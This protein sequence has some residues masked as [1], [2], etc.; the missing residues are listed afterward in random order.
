MTKIDYK[1]FVRKL[2][3]RAAELRAISAKQREKDLAGLDDETKSLIN[4]KLTEL[5]GELQTYATA[6]AQDAI[7]AAIDELEIV[8][9]YDAGQLVNDLVVPYNTSEQDVLSQLPA[10]V[11]IPGGNGDTAVVDVTW[12][13]EGYNPEVADVYSIIGTFTLPHLWTGLPEIYASVEVEAQ[14]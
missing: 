9:F 10:T 5:E 8:M 11:E 6:A 4:T 3:P 14:V 13:I 12:A 1:N 7:T 2:G